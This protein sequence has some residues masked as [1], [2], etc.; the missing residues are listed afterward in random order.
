MIILTIALTIL[1][2]AFGVFAV[3]TA[4]LAVYKEL[5]EDKEDIFGWAVVAGGM[6]VVCAIFWPIALAV[7]WV[8]GY[9]HS[10]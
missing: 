2:M 6:I 1:Y 3:S 9:R 8:V 4:V 10:T 7:F 5:I